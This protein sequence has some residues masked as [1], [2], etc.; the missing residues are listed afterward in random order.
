MKKHFV[1]LA[2]LLGAIFIVIIGSVTIP[3][4]FSTGIDAQ[5]PAKLNANNDA[6]VAKFANGTG[7]LDLDTGG[8]RLRNNISVD[9]P[10]SGDTQ[11]GAIA[12]AYIERT[13]PATANSADSITHSLGFTPVHIYAYRRVN[14][15]TT[16]MQ[17]YQWKIAD[18]TFVYY[19]STVSG[20]SIRIFAW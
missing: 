7:Y 18:D 1:I 6:L 16:S 20:D 11:M 4:K 2:F 10:T 15:D 17:P 19:K 14:M 5:F 9:T 12:M 13:L 3:Y 8:L